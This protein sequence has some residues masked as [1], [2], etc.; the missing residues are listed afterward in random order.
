ME[1]SGTPTPPADP[2]QASPPPAPPPASPDAE[3]RA[4]GGW[5]ALAVILAIALAITSAVYIVAMTELAD[6][7]AGAD[8]CTP[9][10]LGGDCTEYFD[11][12]SAQKT[13][14]LITGWPAGVLAG[15]AALV[16]VYFAATGRR[17][18]LL[19]QLTAATVALGAISILIS[20]F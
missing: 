8:N 9:P 11:G 17:G 16:A 2:P 10:Q 7:P 5:R 14:K 20:A 12:S 1:A 13:A 4:G 18:R 6:L 19:M 15:I 3:E